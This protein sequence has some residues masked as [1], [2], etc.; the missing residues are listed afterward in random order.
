M[1]DRLAALALLL[2][3]VAL[4]VVRRLVATY[5]SLKAHGWI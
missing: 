1:R 4:L 2:G 3:I 5:L